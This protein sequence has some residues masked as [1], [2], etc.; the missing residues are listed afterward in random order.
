MR[1]ARN[2]SEYDDQPITERLLSTDLKH[3]QGIVAAVIAA[4]PPRPSAP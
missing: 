1:R 4:I 3:A 2:R